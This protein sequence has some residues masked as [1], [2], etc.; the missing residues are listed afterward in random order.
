MVLLI[1]ARCRCAGV[2]TPLPQCGEV[3]LLS[4][5]IQSCAD[6]SRM[7]GAMGMKAFMLLNP[8]VECSD[9]FAKSL[10]CVSMTGKHCVDKTI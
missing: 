4:D 7:T 1:P 2:S 8:D 5:G 10:Y 9:P 6:V 3:S